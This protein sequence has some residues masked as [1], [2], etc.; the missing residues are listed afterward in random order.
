[1]KEGVLKIGGEIIENGILP[2]EKPESLS[3]FVPTVKTKHQVLK[4]A[5]QYIHSTAQVVIKDLSIAFT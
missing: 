1:M 4:G 3:E 2:N 5:K